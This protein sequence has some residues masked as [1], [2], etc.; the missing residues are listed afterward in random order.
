MTQH[1]RNLQP[2]PLAVIS[3]GLAVGLTWAFAV[4]LLGIAAGLFDWGV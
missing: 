2:G 3:F 1:V 4:F